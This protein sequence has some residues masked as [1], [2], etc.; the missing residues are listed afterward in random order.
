MA[1]IMYDYGYLKIIVIN[2]VIYKISTSLVVW[3][4][5]IYYIV[6]RLNTCITFILY[7]QN[8]SIRLLSL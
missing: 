1:V 8:K 4:Q 2:F 6:C 3:K 7:T 5:L